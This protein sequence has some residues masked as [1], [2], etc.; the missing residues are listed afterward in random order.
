M[1]VAQSLDIARG[2][3]CSEIDIPSTLNLDFTTLE[4]KY[5]TSREREGPRTVEGREIGSEWYIL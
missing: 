2:L 3:T 4:V 1:K 5:H